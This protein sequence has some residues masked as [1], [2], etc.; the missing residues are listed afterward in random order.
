MPST[1]S[2]EPAALSA[3][4]QRLRDV[5][6]K[7][8]AEDIEDLIGNAIKG[9]KSPVELLERLVQCELDDR[10]RRSLDRRTRRAQVGHF[11]TMNDFDWSW[12]THINR[13]RVDRALAL[14]F[15]RAGNNVVLYGGHG[16]GKTMI[17]KNIA[18]NALAA[19]FTVS[20]VTAQK[21]LADLSAID[22]PSALKRAINQTA[23]FGLL[24]IDEVGYLSY[25]DRAADLLYH[26]VSKRY[27][28]GKSIAISTNLRFKEWG[29]VFPNATC[30]A[31]LIERIVHRAESINIE[32]KSWRL[33]EAELRQQNEGNEP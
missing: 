6:L 22:S 2:P 10:R 19:G 11:K 21:L 29:A 7:A 30:A 27:E 28:A 9:R 23:A 14:D 5:G 18:H 16:L 25:N 3:L 24:C 32:G 12:P 4:V 31:A 26:V 15:L 13:S 33:R 8:P 20:T 1:T 17:L